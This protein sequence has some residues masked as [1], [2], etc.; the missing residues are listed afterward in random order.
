MQEAGKKSA[1]LKKI[2]K[3]GDNMSENLKVSLFL[4]FSLSLIAGA[5]F[6]AVESSNRV[7][8]EK[9]RLESNGYSCVVS[10]KETGMPHTRGK[11]Y[12]CVKD[13]EEVRI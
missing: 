1:R 2:N 12:I 10:K 9:A 7:E 13:G 5:V 3:R 6:L 4:L 11:I 8:S